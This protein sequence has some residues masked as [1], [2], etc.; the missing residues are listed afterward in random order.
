MPTIK[1]SAFSSIVSTVAIAVSAPISAQTPIWTAAEDLTIDGS[2]ANLVT[3]SKLLVDHA[4]RM[5]LWQPDDDRILVFDRN[6]ARIDSIGRAGEGPGEFRALTL[7][8]FRGADLWVNDP[9]ARRSSFFDDRGRFVGSM[10]WPSQLGRD[11]DAVAPMF[12]VQPHG[13]QADGT[14]L[15]VVRLSPRAQPPTWWLAADERTALL[16]TDS[17]GTVR[18]VIMSLPDQVPDSC[19]VKYVAAKTGPGVIRKPFCFEGAMAIASDGSRVVSVTFPSAAESSGD[20][21]LRVARATGEIVVDR[22]LSLE[23][24]RIPRAVGDSARNHFLATPGPF[25]IQPEKRAAVR[26]LRVPEYY[27]PVRDVVVGQDRTIWLGRWPNG[28]KRWWVVLDQNGRM[29]GRIQLPTNLRVSAASRTAVW[30]TRLDRNGIP[31]IV[32]YDVAAM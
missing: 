9:L 15:V 11:G 6:G 2:E 3:T 12:G 1:M 16:V 14:E 21:R 32:R 22:V 5:F 24:V 26:Q 28:P 13:I 20:L 18:Q 8:G 27:P 7:G 25:G 29:T 23:R 19:F 4:G 31:S 10:R 30:G 17:L